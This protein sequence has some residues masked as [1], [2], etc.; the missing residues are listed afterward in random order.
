MPIFTK[1][2]DFCND[3]CSFDKC[4]AFDYGTHKIGVATGNFNDK[5]AFPKKVL[6]GN[7]KDPIDVK[8]VL[9]NEITQEQ[10]EIIVIGLPKNLDGNENEKCLFIRNLADELLKNNNAFN[11]FLIDERFTT[12]ATRSWRNF[13]YKKKKQKSCNRTKNKQENDADDASSASI[14]LD[15]F[16]NMTTNFSKKMVS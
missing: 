5:I 9:L 6:F 15:M 1:V 7:W 14:L 12:K 3:F 13:E 16:F 11:I 10:S 4:I 2:D 8:Y